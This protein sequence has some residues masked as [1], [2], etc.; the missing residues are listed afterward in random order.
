MIRAPAG[1]PP[2][3][4][5]PSGGAYDGADRD[6]SLSPRRGANCPSCGKTITAF[7]NIPL[8]SYLFLRGRCG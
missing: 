3:P 2:P 7:H 8:L 4:R 1:F 5:S 6:L